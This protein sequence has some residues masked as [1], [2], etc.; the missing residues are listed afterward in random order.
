[1]CDPLGH[2]ES[3]STSHLSR[4][5]PAKDT[6]AT[7]DLD[8]IFVGHVMDR[9]SR[10]HLLSQH[11]MDDRFHDSDGNARRATDMTANH[12]HW[13]AALQTVCNTVL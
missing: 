5:H 10:S 8:N 11:S 9:D 4:Q 13:P 6:V 3:N 12:F 2:V 7:K 1:M